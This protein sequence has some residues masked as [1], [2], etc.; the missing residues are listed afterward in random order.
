MTLKRYKYWLVSLCAL[1]WVGGCVELPK[2]PTLVSSI[3]D[4]PEIML[5][6]N[7]TFVS[8]GYFEPIPPIPLKGY[9]LQ[10]L[11]KNIY[12]FST[13]IYN[14]LFVVGE[15]GVLITDPIAGKGH[16]LKRAIKEITDKPVRFMIYTHS[17]LDH[18]GDAYLFSDDAQIIAHKQTRR[19]LK[20][21]KDPKRP[22]PQ[23]TFDRNY[24]LNF[25]GLRIKLIFAEFGHDYGNIIVYI[26]EGKVLMAVD[27]ATPKAVPFKNF[28]TVDIYG[29]IV[30]IQKALELDWETYVAGHLYRPGTRKEMREVLNYYYASKDANASALKQVSFKGLMAKSQSKDPERIFGEYYEA[31][32]EVCYGLL[33]K[34]WKKRLMGFEA[35]TRGH[36]DVWTKFHRTHKK[37]SN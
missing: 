17:H 19:L 14:N 31:V 4:N 35:F 7:N 12:F 34:K 30:G 23:I 1:L 13:G 32:S 37:P 25:S 3:E 24:V 9:L 20:R 16:L 33:K 36:C 27:V 28:S 29:Q 5:S 2:P 18:I 6:N 11:G 21:Y 26:P 10:P 22:L 15:E 8:D